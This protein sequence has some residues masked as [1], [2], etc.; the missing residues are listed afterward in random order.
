M[1]ATPSLHSQESPTP[2]V[3]IVG[4]ASTLRVLIVED[5]ELYV[6]VVRRALRDSNLAFRVEHVT[7]L[8]EARARLGAESVDLVVLDLTLPDST[9]A[10]SFDVVRKEAPGAAVVIFT[11]R[12][13]VAL[14][15][16]LIRRGAE[17]YQV[18]GDVHPRSLTRCFE[19]SI[20]RMRTLSELEHTRTEALSA[21]RARSDFVSAMSH[22]IRTPLTAILGMAELLEN[23]PLSTYQRS[24]VQIFGRCGRSLLSLLDNV[25]DLARFDEHKVELSE[26]DFDLR[27]LAGE[28]VETFALNAHCKGLAIAAE[29]DSR[30]GIR[31]GDLARLR[32]VL[33]NLAGNA[34]KFTQR[35]FVV[36]RITMEG[37]DVRFEVVDSGEGI[38]PDRVAAIFAPFEQ[39]DATTSRQ[40]GGSGLGLALSERITRMMGA[41]I[42][43][44]SEP[45][46]GSRFHFALRLPPGSEP[47]GAAT[48][49]EPDLVG[50]RILLASSQSE[51]RRILGA[52]LR[53]CG[54]RL[55]EAVDAEHALPL[56]RDAAA[57]GQRF[58]V[59]IADSQMTGEGGIDL[60]ERLHA[61]DPGVL[62]ERA[63]ILLWTNHRSS[64]L[65]RLEALGAA[66]ILKPARWD[67][68]ARAVL[69]KRE[70]AGPPRGS[71]KPPC[72]RGCAILVAEDT[73]ENRVLIA[74]HLAPT[75]CRVEM[76]HD[77][78][79]A[80]ELWR[81]EPFD[82]VLMDMRM[83][84][85][86]GFE[87]T[88]RLRADE[89]AR[90]L[91]RTP[92][93]A[94]TAHALPDE[95][96]AC[97]DAGCDGHLAKPFS[98]VSLYAVLCSHLAGSKPDATGGDAGSDGTSDEAGGLEIE[99][100]P[101][102]ADLAGEYL[103]RRGAD[104]A[105][106]RQALAAGNFDRIRTL[107]HNMKGSAASYGFAPIGRIGNAMERAAVE[108]DPENVQ[109][110][111]EGL[112]GYVEQARRA[113]ASGTA[114]GRVLGN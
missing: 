101:E 103:E 98:R 88:R 29:V 104:L 63:V 24:Y 100:M 41:R 12:D 38:A 86:D 78:E 19:Y 39:A 59:L 20:E 49:P 84:G 53:N 108:G 7:T 14:A 96:R 69:G 46:A 16:E 81:A 60:L 58:D 80:L 66:G 52:Q 68:L 91:E 109:R 15:R 40:H 27:K 31:R 54:A 74:A 17:D 18:K 89:R 43:V 47:A 45:G 11:G 65:A 79:Q 5:D 34:V 13:D 99:A 37:E 26:E 97:L 57:S 113:L 21:A 36:L 93:V 102:L 4:D 114:A 1:T 70:R 2:G 67:V 9:G 10:R 87:A 90:G 48:Q 106:L 44:E 35:G 76:A 23:T 112:A 85:V 61:Q 50:R 28:V 73:E 51:E 77:G 8:A 56:L 111:I 71:G 55:E 72:L 105:E 110:A 94:L 6:K 64:D 25:L 22:E 82:L 62:P 95:V 42:E 33:F 107:G 3:P 32:Q 30:A 75:N 83:P 92:V